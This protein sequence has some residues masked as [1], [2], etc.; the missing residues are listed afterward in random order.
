MAQKWHKFHSNA[1]KSNLEIDLAQMA[2]YWLKVHINGICKHIA[3]ATQA[4]SKPKLWQRACKSEP[5]KNLKFFSLA[6]KQ[7][8]F[9]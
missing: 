9:R 8:R 2:Y 4:D 3:K 5:L 1:N 7:E 6:L